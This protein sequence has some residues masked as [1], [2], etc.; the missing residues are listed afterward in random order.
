M[1]FA[2]TCGIA[3]GDNVIGGPLG[4]ARAQLCETH[5]LHLRALRVAAAVH[6]ALPRRQVA[7]AVAIK[8]L[9]LLIEKE[10]EVQTR[11]GSRALQQVAPSKLE[12]SKV[13]HLLCH[14]LHERR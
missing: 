3:H 10:A 8:D 13:V 4:K 9:L 7:H 11:A 12:R 2:P 14:A 5:Q 6:V 1:G